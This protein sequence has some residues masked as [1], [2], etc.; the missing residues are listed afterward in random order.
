MILLAVFAVAAFVVGPEAWGP[1]GPLLLVGTIRALGLELPPVR[2]LYGP[3][4]QMG[5]VPLE[6]PNVK[7]WPGGRQWASARST[8]R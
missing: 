7:G 1:F 3:L 4:N 5:Q 8:T 2:A 6:P